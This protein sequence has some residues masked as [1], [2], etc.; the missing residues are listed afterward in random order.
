MPIGVGLDCGG[1]ASRWVAIDETGAI[2]AEG[3]GPGIS[4]LLFSPEQLQRFQTSLAS[5]CAD[6]AKSDV[7]ADAA[8]AGVTGLGD[9]SPESTIFSKA[10]AK[11]L[12][13]ET[14]V[15]AAFEDSK[16]AYLAA[17]EPGEG[18][19]VYSGTGSFGIHL[20]S[21]S[22]IRRSGGCGTAI[23]DGGSGYWIGREALKWLVRR[24]EGVPPLAPSILADA[25][26]AHIGGNDWPAIRRFAYSDT[27]TN[28]AGLTYPVAGAAT[29]NDPDAID[30]L[31]RAAA[32]MA[33]L[34]ISLIDHVGPKPIALT[35]GAASSH[36]L[37]REAF[38][39]EIARII[40]GPAPIGGDRQTPATAAAKQAL[41]L[42]LRG[43]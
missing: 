8:V 28:L 16:I 34:A 6:I 26:H 10:L 9:D 30:I 17:F 31:R 22:K 38:A 41:L 42:L 3:T 25:L 21:Q 2:C 5:I 24:A 7:I 33:R 15:T 39:A 23:D 14:R 11:G 35:G 43:G 4:G 40:P 12:G 37:I 27:R 32:E 20:D 29:A 13:I 1:G 19:L 36:P 18:I